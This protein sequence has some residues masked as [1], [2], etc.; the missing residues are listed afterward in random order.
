MLHQLVNF[1]IV[2]FELGGDKRVEV[3][4]IEKCF[5]R[6]GEIFFV[7]GKSVMLLLRNSFCKVFMIFDQTFWGGGL[8]G[9]GGDVARTPT[10]SVPL[11]IQFPSTDRQNCSHGFFLNF[12]GKFIS[13]DGRTLWL[14]YSANFSSGMNGQVL[15]LNPPGGRGVLRLHEVKLMDP[16]QHPKN[17]G[18]K[19]P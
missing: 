16:T 6:L 17:E 1:W 7:I 5:C 8:L 15:K 9:D 12:P 11:K 18:R 13:A 19:N 14:C 2:D 3:V 10:R 4:A